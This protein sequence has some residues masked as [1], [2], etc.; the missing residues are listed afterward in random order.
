MNTY[1]T[2]FT[3]ALFLSLAITPILRRICERWGW[4]DQPHEHRRIHSRAIP[5]LGGVAIYLATVVTLAT[6]TLFDNLVTQTLRAQG[7][8]L[9]VVLFPATL[10]LLFGI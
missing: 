5:R 10:L 7:G 9:L 4:V 8:K 2:L 3:L 6:L 1:L